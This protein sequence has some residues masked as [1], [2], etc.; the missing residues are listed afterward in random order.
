[1]A[2]NAIMLVTRKKYAT[3]KK[4]NLNRNVPTVMMIIPP[5]LR[6]LLLMC[7]SCATLL[8][9]MQSDDVARALGYR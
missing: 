1:M 4:T 5:L 9:Y 8:C 7:A 2:W 3:N 6:K